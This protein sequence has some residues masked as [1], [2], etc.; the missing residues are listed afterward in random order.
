MVLTLANA[1]YLSRTSLRIWVN[2]RPQS[3]SI[4]R[5]D[6][7]LGY[8]PENCYWAT[9][10]QQARNTRANRYLTIGDET[11]C[12]AE[13]A[14]RRNTKPQTLWKRLKRGWTPEAAVD[15]IIKDR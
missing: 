6:N 10:I 9:K 1:G 3:I 14:E 4:E 12:L 11:Y 7:S 15:L 5:R 13:W 2:R 8:S